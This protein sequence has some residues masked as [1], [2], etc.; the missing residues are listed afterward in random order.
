M[1]WMFMLLL[2]IIVQVGYS[3]EYAINVP[4][5][6]G[7]NLAL[8]IM[9]VYLD[10]KMSSLRTPEAVKDYYGFDHVHSTYDLNN[11]IPMTLVSKTHKQSDI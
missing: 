2:Q 8:I 1:T 5:H 3:P 7:F 10:Y 11:D 4:R 9:P 6:T